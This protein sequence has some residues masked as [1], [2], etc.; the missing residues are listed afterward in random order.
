MDYGA[1]SGACN[2]PAENALQDHFG[3]DNDLD[4]DSW[5]SLTSV[6]SWESALITDIDNNR[7]IYYTGRR[8]S[9]TGTVGHAWV[10]DGYDNTASTT[11]FHMNWGW[12]GQSDGWFT[13]TEATDPMDGEMDLIF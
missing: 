13:V 10:M 8:T 1:S 2:T 12:G 4:V 7:P 5:G 9:G 6:S 3:Y 11:L